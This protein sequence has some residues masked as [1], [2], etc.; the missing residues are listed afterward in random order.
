MN[1]DTTNGAAGSTGPDESNVRYLPSQRTDR[2]AP[3]GIE[4]SRS[5]AIEPVGEEVIEGEL[6]S[7]E[8]YRTVQKRKAI[9]RYKAYGRDVV[10]AATWTKRV[11]THDRTKTTGKL[12]ARNAIYVGQGAGVLVKR[13]WEAKTNSRYERQ[14]RS[15]EAGGNQELLQ[16]WENRAEQ[17]KQRRHDRT[18]DW[19]RSPWD[20]AKAIAIVGVTLFGVLLAL[21][22]LLAISAGDASR[23]LGPIQ[24]VLDLIEWTVWAFAIAWGP[25]VL[26]APWAGLLTLWHIGRTKA[27]TP[28]WV[29]P[30][31]AGGDR[32][33][34]P[35]EGA[36]LSALRNLNLGPLTA[37]F[38]D[39][40]QPRWPLATGRDGKG[41]RT[42]LELPPGVTVA[43]INDKKDVLAHNLVRLPVEVWP[44]EPKNQPGV[45]DLWVAD[46]GLLTG[47]VAPYPLL[48]DGTCDYFKGVPVGIDQRGDEVYGRLMASNYAIAGIM[49]SGKTSLVINLLS[50][51]M[52]D[53]LVDIDVYVMAENVDYDAMKP[54]LRTLVKGDEEVTVPAVIEAVRE[55][56]SMVSAR[57]R[58]LSELGGEETKLT[59]EIAE[60][61]PRMRP[62]VVVID[63]C[64]ELFMAGKLGE[65]AKDLAIKLMMKARKVGITLIWVTPAPSA[66]SLPRA[67]AKTVSHRV[68]FAIGDHQGN[69][70][71]LGTGAHKRGITAVNLVAGEDVGTAMA[72]GFAARA[73][74]LRTHH[75]RKDKDVDQITPIVNRALDL[76]K[77]AGVT[78]ALAPA[79]V[80]AAV[81][82]PV[83]DIAAVLGNRNRL[84]TQE[85]LALLAERDRTRYGTWT[86]ADLK[87]ALPDVAKPYKYDGRMVV[88]RTRIL[89]AIAERNEIGDVETDET[90]G[91][92]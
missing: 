92:D 76:R 78:A 85:V 69:D 48:T 44:T 61:D 13:L 9:A 30:A 65:E 10:V 46:Q 14:M 63:E 16:E 79:S 34:V 82:D 67:L 22:I 47:P 43:M 7:D 26:L 41:W 74:L 54:R 12:V 90:E 3:A 86:F 32:E 64:Q 75:I 28:A 68:C 40:W 45:L 27:T 72:S 84:R 83:D 49:G 62:R 17:A 87:D 2:P 50:G 53:P 23:I 88:S 80:A 58:I 59:R 18:M 60:R 70:A 57:G 37:K 19:L 35:D 31:D 81:T 36:I 89:E 25:F 1:N 20:F 8:D 33:V 52:L 29:A 39:G 56:R 38:K 51:A 5:T 42:Q 4:Q 77:A 15:A 55:L 6:V 66:D 24:G 73:G 11:A 71:I 91:D 21:G